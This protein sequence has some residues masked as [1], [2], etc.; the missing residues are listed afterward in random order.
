MV[1]P[2]KVA[3]VPEIKTEPLAVK[4]EVKTEVVSTPAISPNDYTKF[5]E[6]DECVRWIQDSNSVA[7]KIYNAFEKYGK[8]EAIKMSCICKQES[9]HRNIRSYIIGANGFWDYGICQINGVHNAEVTKRC[10]CQDWANQ[11]QNN[12]DLNI[13]MAEYVYNRRGNT[14]GA[15]Y[16]NAVRKNGN[17]QYY[18]SNV[19]FSRVNI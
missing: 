10:N 3:T 13:Q 12:V 8:T 19:D 17:I 7:R 11:L 6:M 5:K 16:A 14:F 9:Q 2:E 4:Q 1:A 15:W 18:V